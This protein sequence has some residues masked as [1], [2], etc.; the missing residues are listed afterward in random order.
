MWLAFI[1]RNPDLKSNRSKHKNKG[2]SI[3]YS[4]F[5]NIFY[6]ELRDTLSFRKPRVD[7]CQFCDKIKKKIN[8]AGAGEKQG[9]LI[10]KLTHLYE[11]EAR[12]ASIKYD[13]EV[14]STKTARTTAD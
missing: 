5:R 9:L 10:E 11:S 14:L 4:S 6:E 12:Y 7:T 13:I 3:S 2:G 8:N 1:K